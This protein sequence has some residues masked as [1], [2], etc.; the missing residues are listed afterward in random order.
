MRTRVLACA[1]IAT[2]AGTAP[3]SAATWSPQATAVPAGAVAT[4]LRSVSCPAVR[5]CVAVGTTGPTFSPETALVERWNGATWALD[6]VPPSPGG[7]VGE[8]KDVACTSTRRCVAVGTEGNASAGFALRW[9]GSRWTRLP[10][11]AAPS[12]ALGTELRGVSC[13]GR[14]V[15]V[16]AGVAY[17]PLGRYE[18]PRPLV[19]RWDGSAWRIQPAPDPGGSWLSVDDVSCSSGDAC[20]TV[21]YVAPQTGGEVPL[22]ERWDGRAWTLQVAPVVP[23]QHDHRLS[24]VSCPRRRFCEAVGFATTTRTTQGT[25]ERWDGGG[26]HLEPVPGPL[27]G[28]SQLLGVTCAPRG[29]CSAVGEALTSPTGNELPLFE[30]RTAAGW[31]VEPGRLPAGG[32]FGRLWGV[33]SPAPAAARPSGGGAPGAP[34]CARWPND[35]AD[36]VRPRSSRSRVGCAVMPRVR[37]LLAAL[38]AAGAAVA[39]AAPPAA[40]APARCARTQWVGAWAPPPR[41]PGPG[42]RTRR[43]AWSS[44]RTPA[45]AW[46]ASG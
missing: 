15:C 34:G 3:A 45:A 30:R 27:P 1:V 40:A 33:A 12:G 38:G 36:S 19:E 21:G 35:A 37:T 20:T 10:P 13:V 9:D 7:R 5:F 11:P 43:C 26:W 8:L 16:A 29:R 4:T 32:V 25:A 28:P 23:D 24:G 18:V 39:P 46:R 14:R 2:V 17:F 22:V 31:R 44:P 6:P 42:S 41:P